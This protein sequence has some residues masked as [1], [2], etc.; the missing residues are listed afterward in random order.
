MVPQWC[1]KNPHFIGRV[2]L[3][4]TLRDK[5]CDDKPGKFNHRVALFGMGGVGKT[6][7]SIEYVV[8][9][10]E[11]YNSVFWISVK[12]AASILL[13]FQ[14][15]AAFTKSVNTE[16]T[17]A[18]S[19]AREVLRWLE[20]QSSWLLVLDNVDDI[21]VVSGYLPD[22]TTGQGHLLLT[23]RDPNA[24]GLPAEGLEVEV[25]DSQTAAEMLLMRA[26]LSDNANAEITLEAAKIVD[27]LGFLALAIEQAA[28]FIRESLKDISRF[29][30]VYSAHRRKVLAERPRQNWPYEHVVATTWS[31]S[32]QVV[33]KNPNAT[34][35]LNLLAFLNPDGILVDFLVAGKEGL[36]PPL[37]TL[38][39]DA[40]ERNKLLGFLEQLSLI[41]RPADGRFVR[42]H[43]LI[44]AV[45]K[46]NLLEEGKRNCMEMVVALFLRAFPEFQEDNRQICR[47]YQAQVVQP[48]L[49]VIELRIENVATM[50]LRVGNFLYED[51]KYYESE[52]FQRNAM[53]IFTVLFG[54]EDHLTLTAMNNLANTYGLQGRPGEAAVL[55]EQVLEKTKRILGDEHPNT[56]LVMGDLAVTYGEQGQTTKK[57]Q[58]EEQVLEKRKRILGDDH[59]DT[60]TTMSNLALTYGDQG[61]T[62]EAVVMHEQVLDKRKRILGDDH[63]DTL[64]SMGN[65]AWMYRKQGMSREAFVLHEQVLEKRKRILG[66]EH[67]D[68]LT[69]MLYLALMYREEGQTK[70]AVELGEQVVE[71]TK[72]ILGDK[73]PAT[74]TSMN[75]LAITYRM[76]GRLGEAAVLQEQVLEKRQQIQDDDHPNVLESMSNLALIY[77]NQG[78]M[79]EAAALQEQVTEKRKRIL[80]EEHRDTINAMLNLAIIYGDQGQTAKAAELEEQVLEK[81]TR[82]LGKD[83]PRTLDAMNN[84]AITYRQQGKIAKALEL[85]EKELEMG[86]R[87]LGDDHPD[88][89]TSKNNIA[90]T[91]RMLGGGREIDALSL[92]EEVVKNRKRI[93]GEEHPHT[94]DAMNELAVTY[95]HQ[96]RATEAADLEAQVV[97]KRKTL[98]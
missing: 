35:L 79:E 97:K 70:K 38:L 1:Q 49:A 81:A 92:Q 85:Q 10:R 47:Q 58:M 19:V 8:T 94:L 76:Q 2:K 57:V 51:G 16:A 80:G 87:T 39:G 42:I 64:D 31:L 69:D 71:K 50:L 46:D 90:V 77:I 7:V 67:P 75:H 37:N 20:K 62:S 83:H 65:L 95:R 60:L 63:L 32:F 54:P 9:Y 72:R 93:L 25:F 48:L 34:Q 91:Y 96:G 52:D 74:L 40:F 86:K 21:S 82:I 41:K 4:E 89:L 44:Q 45:I 84:L 36:P 15:I 61:R 33:Q 24:M 28:A 27:E 26:N 53:E 30:D 29:M 59:N 56:L 17:D 23:T 13:G 22:V 98:G 73:N 78:R 68:T 88:T 5:L 14:E 11:K 55:H 12:D 3:L 66:E 6:Q 43:R 18:V